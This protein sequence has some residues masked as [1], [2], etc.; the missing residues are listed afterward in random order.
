MATSSAGLSQ[1]MN[2]IQEIQTRIGTL[3][4]QAGP[5]PLSDS[6]KTD[7]ASQLDVAMRAKNEAP[8]ELHKLFVDASNKYN[9]PWELIESVA[10]N[11]SNFNSKA[12]SPKGAEG[13]MQIMPETQKLLGVTDPFDPAQSIDGGAKYLRMQM[14]QFGGD[15]KRVLAAYNAGPENV[16]KYGDVPPF[17][18]TQ[19][20]VMKNMERIAGSMR[21]LGESF[22]ES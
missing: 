8:A 19:D 3:V 22:D 11:E 2:R 1:V 17:K 18:E 14:D 13:I 4:S 9:I 10:K 6:S 15:M 21:R 12:V 16:K 7:F 20:F 5:P